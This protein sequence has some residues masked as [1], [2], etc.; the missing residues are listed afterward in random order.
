[1][2]TFAVGILRLRKAPASEQEVEADHDPG[3]DH[4][5]KEEGSFTNAICRHGDSERGRQPMRNAKVHL[6]ML[7]FIKKVLE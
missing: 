7:N 1:M 6:H 2:G 3:R 4:T 5:S